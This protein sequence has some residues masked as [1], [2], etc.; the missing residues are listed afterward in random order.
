MKKLVIAVLLSLV[1]CG[2]MRATGQVN[3]TTWHNDNGRTG[4]NTN[5]THLSINTI[6]TTSEFGRL[7]QISLPST[8]Q[9]EQ[10]YAQPLVVSNQGGSMT[11]YV[12]D[13]D[14]HGRDCRV[15]CPLF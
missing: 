2:P 5:E 10:V 14:L 12:L 6:N 3:V 4:R 7:C 15:F 1:A 11:V 8:P 13:G 9:Q